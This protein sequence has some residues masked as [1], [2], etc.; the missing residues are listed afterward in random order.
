[1]CGIFAY[2]NYGVPTKQKAIVDKLL[3]GLRRLE[4][5][6]YDSAGIAIDNGPSLD[7]LS[8]IVLKETGKIDMLAD[9]ITNKENLNSD[10]FFENHCG[11]GHTRW[12]THGPPAPRNSHP[13]TS[14]ANNEFLVVHNGI[15]T[16][17]QA[18][19]EMLER[20]A[21]IQTPALR[22]PDGAKDVTPLDRMEPALTVLSGVAKAVMRNVESAAST[23]PSSAGSKGEPAVKLREAKTKTVLLVDG[24]A[25]TLT[26]TGTAG[27]ASGEPK[28]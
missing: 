9:F 27:K 11:I 20:K 7:E 1:M 6:G 24:S 12:A 15:I 16:N 18:L 19:R 25:E 23:T 4:Y 28:A 22:H 2:V 10:L 13:H 14:D 3:N 21:E 17:H 26:E 8:P 5:R